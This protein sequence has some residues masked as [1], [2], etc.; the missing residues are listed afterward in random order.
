MSI[1]TSVLPIALPIVGAGVAIAL[2]I[3][4]LKRVTNKG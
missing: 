2:G 4:Y 3:K 1:I